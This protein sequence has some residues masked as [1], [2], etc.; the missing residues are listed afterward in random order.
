MIIEAQKKKIKTIGD[1]DNIVK[2]TIKRSEKTISIVIYNNE[3]QRTYIGV[4]LD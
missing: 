2:S 3:N 1:L 4:K